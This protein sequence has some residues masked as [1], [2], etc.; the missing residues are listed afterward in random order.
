MRN[1]RPLWLRS[2][3]LFTVAVPA[4]AFLLAPQWAVLAR[5]LDDPPPALL[6]HLGAFY[7]GAAAAYVAGLF[8]LRDALRRTPR[9]AWEVTL[10]GRFT[11]WVRRSPYE[12]RGIFDGKYREET[13]HSRTLGS[14]PAAVTFSIG[15]A[16][17]AALVGGDAVV[18]AGNWRGLLG[19]AGGAAAALVAAPV[20]TWFAISWIGRAAGADAD[21][22]P[23]PP[24]TVFGTLLCVPFLVGLLAP[25]HVALQGWSL[26]GCHDAGH[27][28]LLTGGLRVAV[29]AGL[30]GLGSVALAYAPLKLAAI[31][32]RSWASGSE[33]W[34]LLSAVY[35]L[36]LVVDYVAR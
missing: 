17:L 4:L 34:A 9:R 21:R 31:P 29:R 11:E 2:G 10:K 14:T 22:T 36:R 27:M 6:E 20:A 7:L 32:L 35:A 1:G 12:Y 8:L 19:V 18:A 25:W 23:V 13:Y 24:C 16:L 15:A 30:L 33:L 26:A 3:I 5:H 28:G